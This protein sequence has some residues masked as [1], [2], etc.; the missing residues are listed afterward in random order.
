MCILPEELYLEVPTARS[1]ENDSILAFRLLRQA[2]DRFLG[3]L[4]YANGRHM[5]GKRIAH[6]TPA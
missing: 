1:A 6:G 2:P 5:I 4:P 3:E